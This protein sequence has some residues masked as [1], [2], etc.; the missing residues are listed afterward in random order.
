MQNSDNR[1]NKDA[2]LLGNVYQ[3]YYEIMEFE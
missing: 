2:V 1:N 3:S